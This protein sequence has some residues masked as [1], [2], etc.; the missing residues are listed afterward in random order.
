MMDLVIVMEAVMVTGIVTV[1]DLAVQLQNLGVGNEWVAQANMK[2]LSAMKLLRLMIIRCGIEVTQL[3]LP[4]VIV[5]VTEM[6][7]GM[8]AE[9][10]MKDGVIEMNDGMSDVVAKKDGVNETSGGM[11]AVVAMRDGVNGT[12]DGMIVD[13]ETVTVVMVVAVTEMMI[14]V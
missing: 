3:I 13:M 1:V 7:G 12:S 11:T 8:T 9:V 5:G 10:A 6:I 14:E 2:S 4:K